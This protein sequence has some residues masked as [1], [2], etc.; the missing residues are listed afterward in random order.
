LGTERIEIMGAWQAAR[1]VSVEVMGSRQ[2]AWIDTDGSVLQEEGV[3]GITLK[4][5]SAEEAKGS[6]LAAGEDLTLVASVPADQVIADADK[7][8][9][10][11]LRIT[12]VEIIS[13][14]R[15]RFDSGVLI[16]TRE[17]FSGLSE[18]YFTEPA[19]FLEPAALIQ[20]DHPII[21]K[22]L[23]QIISEKDAP[24]VRIQKI[25]EW[26]FRN[27]EKRPVLSVP[28]ALETLENRMGDCNEHAVL[29]A[30]F[31][32]AAGIPARI[33]TGLV[34]LRGRFYYHAWNS[35]FLGKWITVDSLMNQIPAD[36]TH[37]SLSRGNPENQFEILG[38]IG[39]IGISVLEQQ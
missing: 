15:Q 19:I 11:V 7:L 4:K 37:I 30:A 3:M 5:I 29:L 1:K 32:R 21:L 14:E 25:T 18:D 8:S 28:N 12:G 16:L 22:Q 26:I 9:R 2:T 36:V 24:V 10:L 35:V 13:T 20:S 23:W 31:A 27:I 39:N 33:E 6:G 34:H 38:A 17:A